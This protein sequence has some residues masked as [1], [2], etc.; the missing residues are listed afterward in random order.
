M[1]RIPNIL[2]SASL[3]IDRYDFVFHFLLIKIQLLRSKDMKRDQVTTK[4]FY[5]CVYGKQ[6]NHK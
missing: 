4:T 2:T 5:C 3:N 1:T 6:K